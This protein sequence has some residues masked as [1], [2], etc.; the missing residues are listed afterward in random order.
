M[1]FLRY[2]Q[3]QQTW[4]LIDRL[5]D[6][7]SR[8]STA[9]RSQLDDERLGKPNLIFNEDNYNEYT[10]FDKQWQ[11]NIEDRPIILPQPNDI[12]MYVKLAD[13]NLKIAR[14]FYDEEYANKSR[15]VYLVM[16]M[17]EDILRYYDYFET[18]FAAI[19]FS[20]TSIEALANICIPWN[21]QFHKSKKNNP[22]AKGRLLSKFEIERYIPLKDKLIQVLP[23]TIHSPDPQPEDWW[24][25][26]QGLEEIRNEIIHTKQSKSEDRYSLLLSKRIFDL[27]EVNKKI[28]SY[29]GKYIDL[30]AKQLLIDF[31]YD[32]GA[33]S[34]QPAFMSDKVFRSY[35]N[36]LHTPWIGDKQKIS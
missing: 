28:I 13:K 25:D 14:A 8:L 9:Y 31:P 33:D 4:I 5:L 29:Y 2:D 6:A 12:S 17:P 1:S 27:I 18:M 30:H 11:L 21:F 23:Q 34:V 3:G 10:Y 36:E 16:L 35:Y 22:T 26:F 24:R 20:Y 15:P 7:S 19:I 32:F